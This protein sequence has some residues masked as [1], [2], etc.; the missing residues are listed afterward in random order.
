M[1]NKKIKT[2]GKPRLLIFGCGDV[3]MRL[4]ALVHERFRVFAVTSQVSRCREIRAAGA[5]PIIA[6]LDQPASLRRLA[7]LASMIVHLVPPQSDGIKDRRTRNLT[8]ILPDHAKLVYISTSG[9][10]GNCDGA[11]IDETRLVKPE[12]ARAKRRLD[13]EATLRCWARR[14]HACLTIVRTP[15]IYGAHR[16][17][18]ERLKRGTPALL[19]DD[20]VFTNHI[21]ADDLANMILAALSKGRPG[22]IYHAVDDSEMKMGT[23]FDAVAD[24]FDLPRP[25]RLPRI[26]LANLVSP[27]LLSFMSESRR[28]MNGR[29]KSELGVRLRYRRV[30]DL[31]QTIQLNKSV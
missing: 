12:N 22:R 9:V 14:A 29:M 20:D 6:N 10:Y 24:A 4:L 7:H 8:A 15:G 1:E 31:L 28:L 27:M 25:P 23:Y 2:V 11:M 18:I 3:G 21:H 26:E 13:A 30:Q 19:P 17:P 16:L 5:I